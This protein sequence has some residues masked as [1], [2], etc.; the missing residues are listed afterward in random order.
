MPAAGEYTVCQAAFSTAG[1]SLQSI[2]SD[3]LSLPD[4]SMHKQQLASS[5]APVAVIGLHRMA[6]CPCPFFGFHRDSLLVLVSAQPCA[7]KCQNALQDVC[8]CCLSISIAYMHEAH[9][10]T[11]LHHDL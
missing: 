11:A 1:N 7:L 6:A 8:V 5:F 4:T 10:L 2:G 9:N 3:M